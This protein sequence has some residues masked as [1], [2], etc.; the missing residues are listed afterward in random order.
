LTGVGATLAFAP[1]GKTLAL[2]GGSPLAEKGAVVKLWDLENRAMATAA[3]FAAPP[4]GVSSPNET[5]ASRA[6]WMVVS[7][8]FS[9]DGTLLAAGEVSQTVE[10]PRSSGEAGIGPGDK[11]DPA[12]S[13]RRRAR[14]QVYD[15]KTGVPK[16]GWEVGETTGMVDVAFTPD[17]KSLVSACGAV[18]F[19]DPGTGKEQ[20]A[21]DTDG[22]EAFLLA[23]SPDGSHVAVAGAR[24]GEDKAEYLVQVQNAV[25][26]RLA[27][28][29]RW[30]D[31]R[32]GPACITFSPD[33]TVLAVG[34]LTAADVRA[35]GSERAKGE[36]HLTPVTEP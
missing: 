36:L 6:W 20:R 13:P 28:T 2:G 23:V 25:T 18:K 16:Q 33:G 24:T 4:A 19:W 9:P 32:M 26:G 34:A 22:L 1:D 27:K 8:T 7:L 29:V 12:R 11:E 17:G 35:Q 3:K 30:E 31:P 21:L 15:S 10:V 14:I 5:M